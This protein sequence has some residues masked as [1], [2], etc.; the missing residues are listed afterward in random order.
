MIENEKLKRENAEL[1]R[2]LKEAES[3]KRPSPPK[4]A[5]EVVVGIINRN[6]G[7]PPTPVMLQMMKNKDPPTDNSKPSPVYALC[8]TDAGMKPFRMHNKGFE[9]GCPP[10]YTFITFD[11][12]KQMATAGMFD[13]LS[14]DSLSEFRKG[15]AGLALADRADRNHGTME[16]NKLKQRAEGKP[17]VAP[18]NA[19]PL[20]L[21]TYSVPCQLVA[22]RRSVDTL[23][24]RIT[25]STTLGRLLNTI[26]ITFLEG[27]TLFEIHIPEP[28]KYPLALMALACN[29]ALRI[30][31]YWN[32]KKD[33]ETQEHCVANARSMTKGEDG[34]CKILVRVLSTN[35]GTAYNNG[36]ALEMSKEAGTM[37]LTSELPEQAD[38][39]VFNVHV[40]TAEDLVT[41]LSEIRDDLANDVD[42]ADA[43]H[44]DSDGGDEYPGDRREEAKEAHDVVNTL[45][46]EIEKCLDD[47]DEADHIRIDSKCVAP[48]LNIRADADRVRNALRKAGMDDVG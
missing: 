15:L 32:R 43:E 36:V 26:M 40:D 45:I 3:G 39:T 2:Q 14:F 12:M 29:G 31:P 10:M 41:D 6:D 11:R 18:S 38:A 46:G 48:A 16:Y 13:E 20:E 27:A 30:V 28:E 24:G 47:D 33:N 19:M 5:T 37:P 21:E 4:G 35:L 42:M 22:T 9:K 1:R 17:I 25:H 7:T 8:C 34:T 44:A 23:Y